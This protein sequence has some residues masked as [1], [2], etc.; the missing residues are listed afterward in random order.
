M[1]G[2]GLTDPQW[3]EQRASYLQKSL[4]PLTTRAS[5]CL[6]SILSADKPLSGRRAA[7]ATSSQKKLTLVATLGLGGTT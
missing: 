2:G 7:S 1:A 5:T 3:S 4:H 6:V